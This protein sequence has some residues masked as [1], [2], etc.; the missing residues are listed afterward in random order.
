MVVKGEP[1]RLTADQGELIMSKALQLIPSCRIRHAHKTR[2]SGKVKSDTW[3]TVDF[4][5]A[6]SIS[7]DSVHVRCGLKS[8]QELGCLSTA[9]VAHCGTKRMGGVHLIRLVPRPVLRSYGQALE[10]LERWDEAG[11][12]CRRGANP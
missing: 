7:G 11:E 4:A 12:A 8:S 2:H 9:S 10:A 1:R 6:L 3:L 5:I